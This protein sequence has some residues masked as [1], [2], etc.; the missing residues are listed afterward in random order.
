MADTGSGSAQAERTLELTESGEARVGDREDE[1]V[2][3]VSPAFGAFFTKTIA[4]IPH[5]EVVRQVLAGAEEQGVSVR[6]VR[7]KR[8]SDLAN[9]A[10]TAAE[11]S[12]SGIG[13]GILSRGTSMIHQKDLARLSNLELFPQSPLLDPDA[14]RHIGGNAAQYAKGESPSPVPVGNDFNSRPRWQAKAA[15]L[16]LKEREYLELDGGVVELEVSIRRAE[17]S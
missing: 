10:H 16:H 12:G 15:L 1:V 4:G 7:V 2:L 6:V 9:I 11:L 13:V 5:A 3:A 17:A 14:Y 8:S